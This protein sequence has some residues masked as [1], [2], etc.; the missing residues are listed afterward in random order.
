MAIYVDDR[1]LVAAH[2]AGDVEAFEEL[3]REYRSPLLAQ[4]KRKL[5][6]DAAA[7]DAVQETLVRAYRALP[8]F[9]GEYRLG[10]WLHRIMTNVCI[11]EAGR[12]VKDQEKTTA[13]RAQPS[14]RTHVPGPEEELGLQVDNGSLDSALQDL[15]DRYREALELRFVEELE[16]DELAAV[17]GVSE[18]NARAR[19]SRAR[20]A[21]RVAMRG[22]AALPVFLFG[23]LKRGEKAAAAA[24]STGAVAASTGATA[25]SAAVQVAPVASATL[26]A[27]TEASVAIGNAA[28]IAMPVIAKAAVG[29]GLA[30]AVLTPTSDSAIHQ[31]FEA[32]SA[33]SG[34]EMLMGDDSLVTSK[35]GSETVKIVEDSTSGSESQLALGAS[36]AVVVESD[37][38]PGTSD[39]PSTPAADVSAVAI[40]SSELTVMAA[41]PNRYSIAGGLALATSDGEFTAVIDPSSRMT[42]EAPD[43]GGRSRIDLLLDVTSEAGEYSELRLAG[44]MSGNESGSHSAAGLFRADLPLR[45]M[46]SQGSFSGSFELDVAGSLSSLMLT[47]QSG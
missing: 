17:S 11:D 43:A 19:V 8:N 5:Y 1:E 13:F 2:R 38:D 44:F 30:A 27:I 31:A 16:Y 33:E 25:T 15:P 9:N 23:L 46:P 20:S 26:P 12:R 7:E 24:S 3:V 39:K 28:P 21:M 41:G 35:E 32:Y 14:A 47:L 6:C 10:P 42:I 37:A 45:G 22:V 34:T 4:A 36:A 29:L 40:T 18:A